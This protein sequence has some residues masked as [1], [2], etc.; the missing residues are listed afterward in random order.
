[1]LNLLTLS[2]GRRLKLQ[3][4]VVAEIIENMNDGEWL[5]VRSLEVKDK[6]EQVGS[7]ELAHATDILAVL[8]HE[9]G[10]R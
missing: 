10:S 8:D 5:C 6:P 4:G 3:G 1:M 2:I 9:A 7:E